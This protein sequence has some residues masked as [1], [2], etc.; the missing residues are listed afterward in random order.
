M[1]FG[2]MVERRW[3]LVVVWSLVGSIG[4]CIECM[5]VLGWFEKGDSK[6]LLGEGSDELGGGKGG[7]SSVGVLDDVEGSVQWEEPLGR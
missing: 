1:G 2:G 4:E 6:V 5:G 3:Q 7:G